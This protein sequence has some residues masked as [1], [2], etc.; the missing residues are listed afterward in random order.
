MKI[1]RI[2]LH[3][4][5]CLLVLMALTG[6]AGATASKSNKSGSSSS[7]TSGSGSTDSSSG[8]PT[9]ATGV[10]TY[11]STSALQIGTIV[12]LTSGKTSNSVSPSTFK[13]MQNMYGVVIDPNALPITVSSNLPNQTY[14]ANSGRYDVLVDTEGG[15]IKAGDYVTISNVDGVAMEAGT[16]DQQHMVFGRAAANFDG[17]SNVI[18][19]TTLK[20]STG[21]T[22]QTVQIGIIPVAISIARNPN[23]K[24]TKVNLPPFFQQ[25]GQAVAQKPIGPGKIYMSLIITGACII[26]A[27]VTL[28]AGIRNAVIAIGRNPLSK[29]SIFRGLLEIIL[30]S[31]LILIIGLFAVYLLLKL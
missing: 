26:V 19:S 22:Y 6:T 3:T 25:L 10:Q 18:D 24:S 29:K 13:D 31:F 2:T 14:V 20:T 17:K 12:Q 28:Y 16:Y 23:Q 30:T 1:A 15:P 8:Q 7:N 4:A 5:F 27:L 11:S 21:N 9:N